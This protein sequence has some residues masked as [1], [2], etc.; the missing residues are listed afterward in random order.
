MEEEIGFFVKDVDVIVVF[1]LFFVWFNKFVS[2]VV[3]I[4]FFDFELKMNEVEVLKIFSLFFE[5]FL[6]DDVVKK[7]MVIGEFE[8]MIFFFYDM[9][10]GEKI[11]IWDFIVLY[12]MFVG[13]VFCI[14]DYKFE[15]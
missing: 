8:Y 10:D 6:R 1:F 14:F 11:E 9:V 7:D 2:L 4:I 13:L 15:V 5:R 12:C 3:G